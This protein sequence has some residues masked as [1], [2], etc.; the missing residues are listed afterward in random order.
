MREHFG[1]ETISEDIL[2]NLRLL[3]YFRRDQ[4][5]NYVEKTEAEEQPRGV[6]TVALLRGRGELCV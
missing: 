3:Q 6:A 4:I 2:L 5:R 1:S